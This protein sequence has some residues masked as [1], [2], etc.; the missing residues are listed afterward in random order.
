MQ[1][2]KNNCTDSHVLVLWKMGKKYGHSERNKSYYS[3]K[4]T[5]SDSWFHVCK[6]YAI[7]LD[8]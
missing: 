7:K 1:N 4:Q 2:G 8:L 5:V 6:C 3:S